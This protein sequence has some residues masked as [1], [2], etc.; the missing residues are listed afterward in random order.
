VCGISV[1]K[2]ACLMAIEA[3]AVQQV[4]S[5]LSDVFDIRK[6]VKV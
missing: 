6:E 4:A 5:L 1:L 2:F 3:G